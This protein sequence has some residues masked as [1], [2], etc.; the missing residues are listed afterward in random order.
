[1]NKDQP[2][3]KVNAHM[4]RLYSYSYTLIFYVVG[5]LFTSFV[6]Y[7]HIYVNVHIYMLCVG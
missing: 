6:V 5:F 1:M 2:D 7:S 3:I 4:C